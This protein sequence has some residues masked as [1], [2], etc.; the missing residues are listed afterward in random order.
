MQKHRVKGG[1]TFPPSCSVGVMNPRFASAPTPTRSNAEHLLQTFV[2]G[3][4]G[5][6]LRAQL[7]NRHPRRSREEVD[8]A[9]QGACERFVGSA[10][11]IT[12]PGEVYTW[13]RTTADRILNREDV[14]RGRELVV[15]PI[16]G[17][18]DRAPSAEPGPADQILADE[19]T[20]EMAT[21]VREVAESLSDRRR[22]VL[23][24]Y[25]AGHNRPEIAER[26]RLSDRTVKREL[27]EGM[28]EA[29]S[30]LARR[31]GGG[32]ERGEPLVLK[33]VYGL[34]SAAEVAQ[35]RAHLDRCQRCSGFH[36]QLLEWRAK[37]AEMLP[38]PAVAE[39]ASPG[40]LERV[41][42]KAADG[43]TSIKQ[44]IFGVGAQ[45]KQQAATTYYRAVDP[46][47]LAGVRPTAVAAV[48]ASCITIGGG[49]A[50]YCANQ[51]VNPIGAATGL[52]AGIEGDEAEPP[53]SYQPA[54]PQEP[55]PSTPT[56]EPTESSSPPAE[57]SEPE[58][59]T[60]ESSTPPA[61]KSE[62]EPQPEPEPQAEGE[63]EPI[64]EPA[65]EPTSEAAPTE[66]PPEP[67]E[68]AK[69]APVQSSSGAGEFEP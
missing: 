53:P 33:F 36:E 12:D 69:P 67:T 35:A 25:L 66:A 17:G 2:T 14:L 58:P 22:N 54:E 4:R 5:Q 18:L 51:G 11:E 1:T 34:A 27:L 65:Q 19:D 59:T 44:Q 42:N 68:S 40:L 64:E 57:K 39:A 16:E 20:D 50:A 29:R 52:I 56:Y 3:E 32:C 45:A 55:E 7:S 43:A 23:A 26:L 15:D 31:T 13:L 47:P 24:L 60:P 61:E 28:D 49:A 21:L 37:A 62:P 48:V 38:A 30:A 63:F 6:A 46:T 10:I 9:V 41:A 8:D